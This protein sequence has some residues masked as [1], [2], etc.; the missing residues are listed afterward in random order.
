MNMGKSLFCISR[1]C[2][3]KPA[4]RYDSQV[5]VPHFIRVIVADS[6][7]LIVHVLSILP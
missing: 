7:G 6:R 3:I 5:A 2:F 4:L 1:I